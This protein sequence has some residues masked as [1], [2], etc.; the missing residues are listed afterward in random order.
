MIDVRDVHFHMGRTAILNGVSAWA[1]PGEITAII[2]PNGSGKTTLLRIMAGLETAICSGE[3]RLNG[4]PA[5]GLTERERAALRAYVT[6]VQQA[7]VPFTVRDFIAFGGYIHERSV[8]VSRREAELNHTLATFQLTDRSEQPV[9]TL[10]GG[11]RQRTLLAKALYQ[12]RLAGD[13]NKRYIFLDEPANHLDLRHRQEL[14]QRLLSLREQGYGV[15][16]VLHELT[17]VH[18]IADHVICLNHGRVVRAGRPNFTINAALLEEVFG[19]NEA[20]PF[21]NPRWLSTD[22][23][24]TNQHHYGIKHHE[25]RVGRSLA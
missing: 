3:V 6:Q 1:Q 17:D 24:P 4:L 22:G 11:E 2:G 25:H 7:S 23:Q 14:L 15:I 20:H 13:A 12:L 18:L 9:A 16:V 21:F 8:S 19:L 10:S 5:G